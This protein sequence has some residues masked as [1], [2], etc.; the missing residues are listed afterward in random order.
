MLFSKSAD[1]IK[2]PEFPCLALHK[3][4]LVVPLPGVLYRIAFDRA[5][6]DEVLGYFKKNEQYQSHFL[7]TDVK[8]YDK[9]SPGVTAK[10]ID[11]L[12]RFGQKFD[13]TDDNKSLYICLIPDKS[14]D[15][16]VGCIAKISGVLTEEEMVTI[17]F[18]AIT[19]STVKTPLLNSSSS[20]WTS[21]V[22]ISD[23]S[24]AVNNLKEEQLQQITSDFLLL[25]EYVSDTINSFRR[26]YKNSAKKGSSQ[27]LL[28][29]SP[30]SNT[31]FFQLEK[32][33]FNK[34]W[35]TISNQVDK[36]DTKSEKHSAQTVDNILYLMDLIVA[37][38]PTSVAQK[39]EFLASLQIITR[40]KYFKSIVES[41][42]GIFSTLYSS[43]DYVQRYFSEASNLE[44][45]KLIAN[46]LKSLR[47]YIEDVKSQNRSYSAGS[48]KTS[49]KSLIP[50]P[51]AGQK[52]GGEINEESDDGWDEGD[53][54]DEMEKLKKFINK[55]SGLGV[56]EDG[57]KMLKKDYKRL[58]TTNPQSAEYQV[59]RSYF[60]IVADI[61]FGKYTSRDDIDLEKSR[62]KLDKDHYGLHAVKKRL[63][64]YLCVLKLNSSLEQVNDKKRRAP[65][66]LLVGPPGVGKTSIAQSV[67]E[68][69]N[70]KFQRVSLGG[71]HN[72]SEI[73]GHRRT[74][75][76]SM[77][78]LIINALKKS[79]RMNPLIL[80]DEVD[81]VL[82][83]TGSGSGYGNKINGDPGAALLEVLDPEQ[84]N[85]FTDHYLGFPV[86]L[87]QVLFF[88]TG[89]DLAGISRPLLDRM[90]VI[91]IPGYTSEEKIQIGSNFLLPKQIR[92]NG[93]GAC[94][95]N[96]SLTNQAWSSLVLEYTRESGVRNLER[97]LASIVRGKIVEFVR[98]GEHG[99]PDEV[100]SRKDLYKYLGF[101][102]HPIT[103]ELLAAVRVADREGIVNGLSYNSDGTGSV[104]VL[105]TIKTGSLDKPNGPTIKATGNLGNVL[106]E[107]IDIG[108]SVV[109]SILRRDLIDGLDKSCLNEF[110]SS[111]YHLHVPMGA[112]SK[113]GPSA[114]TAIT[115]ALLSLA[116]KRPVDPLLCMT[117]EITLRGKILPVGGVKEKLLGAKMYG[118]KQVLV[119]TANR[120]DVVQAVTDDIV[121]FADESINA[122]LELVQKQMGLKVTYVNDIYDVIQYTWPELTLQ[123]SLSTTEHGSA[124][125]SKI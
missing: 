61:P 2:L 45:S 30:L 111:E 19:R 83:T 100:V 106:Q 26:T 90:E 57:V 44:K 84:N 93:L 63:M 86:D 16:S 81:K 124:C 77:C 51:S 79:G 21:D 55:L 67:A 37:V 43:A 25:F 98:N 120:S 54:D 10:S 101:P 73:R 118:M 11:S 68:M 103:T 99:S 22:S 48:K 8:R 7:L 5:V 23:D 85:T 39:V 29:L 32:A 1:A 114:G 87:S 122:E 96:F 33:H 38:L 66:L 71:V 53:D 15:L 72:E 17:S 92:V 12:D 108:R 76:G 115:L 97:Q 75:V 91:E 35:N 24:S 36:L 89:N 34:A 41:F 104:L 65:I 80:L 116:L 69:L 117:G 42:G 78:G 4:P 31:L 28:L 74:Y 119:P 46:Q 95:Q 27:H 18:K 105:E 88:C 94:N 50:S 20:I 59:L 110:L 52:E 3:T 107:S 102:L 64:E 40:F 70:L 62:Q 47:F 9:T 13:P 121:P 109:K 6:G 113:D 56:H 58:S 125:L 123:S 82:S 49:I 60:D 14:R 112:V